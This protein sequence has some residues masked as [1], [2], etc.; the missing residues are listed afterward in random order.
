VRWLRLLA[1]STTTVVAV[2]SLREQPPPAL[3]GGGLA[4][5]IALPVL[6]VSTARL[7]ARTCGRWEK[8]PV[9][10]AMILAS[11]AL[12]WTQHG[13]PGIAGVFIAVGYAAMRLPVPRSLAML[14]LAIVAS[15]V[16]AGHTNSSLAAV[17][18]PQLGVLAFYVM[19]VFA[20]RA[21]EAHEQTKGLLA[22]LEAGR[23]L[24]EEAAALRERS[25]IARE[26]HDVLAHSLS[27]LM[28]Q[29]EGARMLA[30][31]PGS[32]G[33][34]AAALER[35]H[36]LARA[37]LEEARHA[38][39]ALRDEDLPGPDRLQ[40]L[41]ADFSRDS[42]IA[43]RL[44]VTGAPRALDSETSL[45]LYRVAQEA[46][47]NSRK[48]A[49]AQRVELHLDYQPNGTRLVIQDHG[50]TPPADAL[51]GLGDTQPAAQRQG[52]GLTGMRERA[53]LLGGQLDAAPTSDG[54]RVELWVPT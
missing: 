31:T 38:I 45:T 34:L 16:A 32:N 10:V 17:V 26:M 39:G 4:V 19:G 1:V 41:T 40:Q 48:H 52:Y 15:A 3:H 18:G 50:E 24:R 27:G 42:R 30:V 12:A 20:R 6:V 8:M 53:E 47:T 51:S 54:F 7:L 22:E 9:L 49:L 29:L 13:G 21:Q 33:Q 11:A 44:E 5:A 14:G 36:H 25:R 35:A 2:F 37:G 46:L 23:H 43:A 28:L